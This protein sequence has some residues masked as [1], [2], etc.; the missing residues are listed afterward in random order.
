[1]VLINIQH[2]VNENAS[3][4]STGS[5]NTQQQVE[6]K[7]IDDIYAE[8][9]RFVNYLIQSDETEYGFKEKIFSR[10]EL[11]QYLTQKNLETFKPHPLCL[12][13]TPWKELDLQVGYASKKEIAAGG[14]FFQM[15]EVDEPNS[16]LYCSFMTTAYD[17]QLGF[18]RVSPHSTVITE[19]D[20]IRH[21]HLIEI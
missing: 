3:S 13:I 2:K 12:E 1:M 21:N 14:E 16:I 20:T 18:Y 17:I 8:A 15:I 6:D 11:E 19:G 10:K 5:R 7:Q 4:K 9:A